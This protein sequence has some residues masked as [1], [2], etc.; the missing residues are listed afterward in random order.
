MRGLA[1]SV[2][3]LLAVAS[4]SPSVTADER[5]EAKDHFVKGTKAFDLGAYDEAVTEYSL[6]YRLHDDPALLYNIAQAHRLAGHT[7][8]AVR[9]YRMF[10]VRNPKAPNRDEV[11]LKISE[12][13]KLIDQQQRTEHLPP[14]QTRPPGSTTPAPQPVPPSTEATPP[15]S[16][17]ATTPAAAPAATT[18][19][20]ARPGRTK[21]IAGLVTAGVGVAAVVVGAA[22]GGLA[23]K[24]S[25]DL[26]KLDQNMQTFDPSKQSSG[27]TDQLLEGVFLGVGGAAI[28]AGVV[29]YVLGHREAKASRVAMTP[30]VGP[31]T[32]GAALKMSF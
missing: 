31:Q 25:D 9:F 11:E 17:P 30:L 14:D 27:K 20:E 18:E 6:A 10:L 5:N 24:A 16:T 29:V 21:K 26:T 7:A 28:V 4:A 15:S 1:A 23:A 22:F 19:T 12:L 13:Q 2:V 3:V 8:E 32:M